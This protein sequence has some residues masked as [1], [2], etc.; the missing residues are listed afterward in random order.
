MLIVIDEVPIFLARLLRQENGLVPTLLG[1]LGTPVDAVERA[2]ESEFA[3]FPQVSGTALDI[4]PSR[5]P[6]SGGIRP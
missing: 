4:G 1:R 6:F 3:A 2:L 5:G